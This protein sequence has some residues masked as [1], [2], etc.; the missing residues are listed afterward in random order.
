MSFVSNTNNTVS[1]L[2]SGI[3][4]QALTTQLLF[5]DRAPARLAEANSARAQTRLDA[6]KAMNTRILAARD[7]LDAVKTTASFAV[8][9]VSVANA[10]A[11]SANVSS[12]AAVGSF[13]V[14][15]KN[16]ATAHQV[17]TFGQTSASDPL[18]AGTLTFRLASMAV[19]DPTL[20]ITPTTNTLTGLAAAINSSN[21]GLTASIINDGSAAPYRLVIGS[22]KTGESN[23]ITS[24]A[25]TGG[26]EEIVPSLFDTEVVTA[27]ADAEIRLGDSENGLLLRS[28][29]N[30]MDVAIPGLT[31]ALKAKADNIAVTISQDANATRGMVKTM[32]DA[33][34][35]SQEFYASNSRYDVATKTAGALFGDYDLRTKLSN[36]QREVGKTF[37]SQPVGFQSLADLG[38]TSDGNGKFTI[39]AAVFDAKL[40]ANPS[41]VASVFN[42]AATAAYTPMEDM[43]RSVNGAMA[44]KQS[45]LE[46]QIKSFADRIAA[47]DARLEQRKAFYQAKFLAMEKITARMQGQGTSL[48]NFVNG[49]NSSR[50]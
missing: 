32:V 40:A 15:V 13:N 34:N 44:L 46:Q 6:I 33:L 39:D 49:L 50:K 31:L 47:I 14:S 42:A 48:T 10:S 25:G 29:S 2:A 11:L 5:L 35:S 1:G 4:T 16:L 7:A 22:A 27:G 37:N 45:G 38:V 12:T 23:A 3:D 8:K 21:L 28:A 9:Q 18:A 19:S 41:A 17:A 26:F 24:L 43:T 36:V 30:N 20:E